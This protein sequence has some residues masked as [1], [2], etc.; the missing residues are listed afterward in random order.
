MLMAHVK[1]ALASTQE[2]TGQT[3]EENSEIKG[4]HVLSRP[5]VR[6]MIV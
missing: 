5:K 4:K 6:K 3:Q 1:N 2:K